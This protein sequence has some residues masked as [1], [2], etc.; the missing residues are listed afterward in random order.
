MSAFMARDITLDDGGLLVAALILS[1][2]PKVGPFADC[3]Q[4]G[5]GGGTATYANSFSCATASALSRYVESDS[6]HF[7]TSAMS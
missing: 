7:V 2:R 4:L 1:I 5:G 6:K 3:N